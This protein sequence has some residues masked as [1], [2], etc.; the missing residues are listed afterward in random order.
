CCELGNC[1]A[2]GRSTARFR[3]T[4]GENGLP[5][6]RNWPDGTTP[7]RSSATLWLSNSLQ[8]RLPHG[9]R[10]GVRHHARLNPPGLPASQRQKD[11]QD[12]RHNRPPP[13]GKCAVKAE[14]NAAEEQGR[15]RDSGRGAGS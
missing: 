7:R 3:A 8:E 12:R 4:T 15:D 2:S 13:V 9:D 14:V 1:P 10:E 5:R 6:G 11:A